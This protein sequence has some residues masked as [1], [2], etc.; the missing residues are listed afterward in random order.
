[1]AIVMVTK[2]QSDGVKQLLKTQTRE[3]ILNKH[4][5][6]KAKGITKFWGID[7]LNDLSNEK[8]AMLL[9][10]PNLVTVE[11]SLEDHLRDAYIGAKSQD[12]AD[13][14]VKAATLYGIDP[15]M[16]EGLVEWVPDENEP[17]VEPDQE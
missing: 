10:N 6:A 4:T 16:F 9:Y 5:E 14:L 11:P 7:G 2:E 3:T 13:G 17:A 8:M 15:S 12:F 1:M